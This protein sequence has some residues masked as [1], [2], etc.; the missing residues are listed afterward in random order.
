MIYNYD[1]IQGQVK[2]ENH[3]T[4]A[5]E[6]FWDFDYIEGSSSTPSSIEENPVWSY[7]Y[8]GDYTIELIASTSDYCTDTSYKTY[9]M[10]FVS[11]FIPNAFSPDDPNEDVKTF[12][13]SGIG[14]KNYNIEV[15]DIWGTMVWSSDKITLDGQP[16]GPGWDGTYKG[17]IMPTGV[18]VWKAYAEFIDGSIWKGS[19][20]GDGKKPDTQGS[21]MLIR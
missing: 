7:S 14:L 4:G 9:Y 5:I 16:A 10:R 19:D 11:L 15:F 8:D 13:P 2:F 17:K 3:S 18:Y 6:Y 21:V 12:L 1:D 20:I